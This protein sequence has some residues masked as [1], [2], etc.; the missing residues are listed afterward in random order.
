MTKV[1]GFHRANVSTFQKIKHNDPTKETKKSGNCFIFKKKEEKELVNRLLK[2]Q[3]LCYIFCP[4]LQWF[5]SRLGTERFPTP[6]F[7]S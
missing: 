2:S 4:Y 3:I 6:C 7:L 1:K 5:L